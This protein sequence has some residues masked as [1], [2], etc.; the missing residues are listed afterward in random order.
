M[1]YR[2][3]IIYWR[4]SFYGGQFND[5]LQFNWPDRT[6]CRPLICLHIRLSTLTWRIGIGNSVKQLDACCFLV[7]TIQV[8]T[9][10]RYSNNNYRWIRDRYEFGID[11]PYY[12]L[13]RPMENWR[14]CKRNIYINHF[15]RWLCEIVRRYFQLSTRWFVINIRYRFTGDKSIQSTYYS[16]GIRITTITFVKVTV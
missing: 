3:Y 8:R 15:A 11:K 9:I 6:T 1:I 12:E 13:I 5:S 10:I 4:S 14:W 16:I 7:T 2:I